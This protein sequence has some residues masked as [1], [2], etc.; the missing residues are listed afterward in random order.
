MQ[1]KLAFRT[2]ATWH[3]LYLQGNQLGKNPATNVRGS[4]NLVVT[5]Y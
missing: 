4:V 3:R 5:Q 1:G 2:R